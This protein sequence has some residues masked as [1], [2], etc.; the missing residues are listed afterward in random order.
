MKTRKVLKAKKLEISTIAPITTPDFIK[1]NS[2]KKAKPDKKQDMISPETG[3]IMLILFFLCF[4][5]TGNLLVTIMIMTIFLIFFRIVS[6]T[7]Q[8]LQEESHK[9][10]NYSID[11]YIF[12]LLKLIAHFNAIIIDFNQAVKDKQATTDK[13]L[14]LLDIKE[15]LEYSILFASKDQEKYDQDDIS[16]ECRRLSLTEK[17]LLKTEIESL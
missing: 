6:I 15:R 3:I 14:K 1:N 9:N 16:I 2:L 13:Y 7:A 8:H 11:S 10:Q 4:T 5:L 12:N 17:D